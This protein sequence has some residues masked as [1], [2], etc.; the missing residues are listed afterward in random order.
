MYLSS[1][2]RKS[3]IRLFAVFAS[4]PLKRYKNGILASE[5]RI[6]FATTDLFAGRSVRWTTW[7]FIEQLCVSNAVT[8][9][10]LFLSGK[11]RRWQLPPHSLFGV[12]KSRKRHLTDTQIGCHCVYRGFEKYSLH[13]DESLICFT[14]ESSSYPLTELS[15]NCLLNLFGSYR[16]N[17]KRAT[18]IKSLKYACALYMRLTSFSACHMKSLII[19]LQEIFTSGPE[20]RPSR[21]KQRCEHPV[22]SDETKTCIIS[23]RVDLINI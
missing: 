18:F 12:P 15:D 16:N 19:Q 6:K 9:R 5:Y 21:P 3:L 23:P 11:G 10:R 4:D 2:E 1:A 17:T 14:W 22:R 7:R 20:F 8:K 13:S